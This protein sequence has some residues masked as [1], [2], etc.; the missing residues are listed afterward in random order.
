MHLISLRFSGLFPVQRLGIVTRVVLIQL[1]FVSGFFFCEKY[2]IL[3]LEKD[4]NFC[5]ILE[6]VGLLEP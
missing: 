3:R 4:E 1:Q 6:S 5:V 2:T